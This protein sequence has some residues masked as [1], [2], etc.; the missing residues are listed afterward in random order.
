VRAKALTAILAVTLTASAI[1]VWHVMTVTPTATAPIA[2]PAS[3]A[4]G[5]PAVA[6]TCVDEGR[7]G[8]FFSGPTT[9][10]SFITQRDLTYMTNQLATHNLAKQ[11]TLMRQMFAAYKVPLQTMLSG[12][13]F[14]GIT[15][16]GLA[17]VFAVTASYELKRPIKPVASLDLNV[18]MSSRYNSYGVQCQGYVAL[19]NQL[20]YLIQPKPSPIFQIQI[21]GIGRDSSIDNH[22]T[23]AT[24]GTGVSLY[25]DP[26]TSIVAAGGFFGL[27][28]RESMPYVQFPVRDDAINAAGAFRSQVQAMVKTGNLDYRSLMYAFPGTAAKSHYG[29]QDFINQVTWEN[30]SNRRGFFFLTL[31][32]DSAHGVVWQITAG[33]LAQVSG[34][35]MVSIVAV[36][37]GVFGLGL[38]GTLWEYTA[39]GAPAIQSHVAQI[40]P[41]PS[42][43]SQ[44]APGPNNK[45]IYVRFTSGA[46]SLFDI[47]GWH[48]VSHGGT[49]AVIGTGDSTFMLNAGSLYQAMPERPWV[50]VGRG[51]DGISAGYPPRLDL[52]SNP[53]CTKVSPCNGEY[54]AHTTAANGLKIITHLSSGA[55]RV[56]ASSVSSWGTSPLRGISV[57]MLKGSHIYRWDSHAVPNSI[58][59]NIKPTG[60]RYRDITAS[61]WKETG[62]PWQP[63]IPAGGINV[64]SMS[65]VGQNLWL[66]AIASNGTVYQI[67]SGTF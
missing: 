57:N 17:A 29:R 8:C 5:T 24:T 47:N 28:D 27:L 16:E 18:I 40:A 42:D 31:P 66:Q 41:G 52:G 58:F 60:S 34:A 26:T 49:Q 65:L 32:G 45:A 62:Q 61:G 20:F 25:L 63:A 33:G 36:D 19:A 46:L 15:D 53:V 50:L 55:Q 59:A 12:A 13:E 51:Y 23:M 38:R 30:I 67:T 4:E 56:I 7:F 14:S 2:R 10:G 44:A 39:A 1:L 21:I 6:A 54:Y 11:R 3:G 22:V 64:N 9:Q 43:S 48:A 37:G 35:G